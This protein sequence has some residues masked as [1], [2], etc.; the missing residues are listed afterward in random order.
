MLQSL[1]DRAGLSYI[2]G[3]LAYFNDSSL[4]PSDP[5]GMFRRSI[6]VAILPDDTI[7]AAPVDLTSE[8][9]A[10]QPAVFSPI[11]TD[12]FSK[13]S[14]GPFF[15][16]S[17]Y[18]AIRRGPLAGSYQITSDFIRTDRFPNERAYTRF[19]FGKA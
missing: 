17:C 14:F 6:A 3:F 19:L 16:R 9:A 13:R 10:Q 4:Y 5:A 8:A 11:E 7:L 12:N 1:L 15:Y 2:G 18:F